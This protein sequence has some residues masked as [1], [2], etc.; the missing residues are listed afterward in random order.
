MEI[1]ELI[2]K[3]FEHYSFDNMKKEKWVVSKVNPETKYVYVERNN[4][5]GKL[6]QWIPAAWVN[7]FLAPATLRLK[8][9]ALRKSRDYFKNERDELNTRLSNI[10]SSHQND[11]ELI[12]QEMN[13]VKDEL[14]I[15][16][17]DVAFWKLFCFYS[18]MASIVLFGALMLARYL[19][20]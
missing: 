7:H 14:L 12:I 1:N 8:I 2:G 10:S 19:F 3:S 16:E 20:C 11:R 4:E 18:T 15:S 13:F 17:R 6:C 5:N 9:D